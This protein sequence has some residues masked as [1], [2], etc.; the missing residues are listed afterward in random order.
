MKKY[1]AP[2]IDFYVFEMP[3]AIMGTGTCPTWCDDFDICVTVG[4][5][6]ECTIDRC[7]MDNS[8][9]ADLSTP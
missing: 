9:S 6:G 5:D 2:S 3:E 7:I 8:C 1:E 4:P